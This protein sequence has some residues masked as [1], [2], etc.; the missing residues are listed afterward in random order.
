[1][2]GALFG[3]EIQKIKRLMIS[4][5]YKTGKGKVEDKEIYNEYYTDIQK[6]VRVSR[7]LSVIV[8]CGNSTGGPFA[9]TMLEN[10][11]VTVKRLHC[12]IDPAFPNHPP[13]PVDPKA[14]PD[15]VKMIREAKPMGKYQLGLLFDGD[16]DRLGAVDVLWNNR[17]K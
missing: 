12:D 14:Y 16:A 5:E 1:G 9:P 2:G 3:E 10:L 11:G 17:S 13:D 4:E 8:D 6:R 7:P 15:I